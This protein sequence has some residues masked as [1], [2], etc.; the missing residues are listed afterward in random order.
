[1][2]ITPSSL[3]KVNPN[4]GIKLCRC[5]L[6]LSGELNKIP[7]RLLKDMAD[8]MEMMVDEIAEYEKKGYKLEGGFAALRKDYIEELIHQ[9]RNLK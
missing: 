7:V 1:M 9:I 2:T 8:E 6:P 5:G 4:Y 3:P